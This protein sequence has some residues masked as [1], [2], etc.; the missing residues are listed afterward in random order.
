MKFMVEWS[1]RP[2]MTLNDDLDNREALL[3]AFAKWQPPEGLTIHA[4]VV[5]TE[6]QAG[7]I[8]VEA[9]DAGVL[10]RFAAPFQPWNDAKQV[11][12]IDIEDAVAVYTDA[13]AWTRSASK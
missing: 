1:T 8:L 5:K 6:Q 12:V 9:D 10:A 13:L 2:G 4:F 7:Y 3:R 11:P